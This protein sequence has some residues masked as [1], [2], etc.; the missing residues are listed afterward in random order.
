MSF[1]ASSRLSTHPQLPL[2]SP[3][4]QPRIPCHSSLGNEP[5]LITDTDLEGIAPSTGLKYHFLSF[6][7]GGGWR[8]EGYRPLLPLFKIFPFVRRQLFALTLIF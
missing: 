8:V 3:Q 2:S 1:R 5:G 7:W 6:F 4:P